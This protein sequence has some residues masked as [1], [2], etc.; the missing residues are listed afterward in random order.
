[1]VRPVDIREVQEHYAR[2]ELEKSE[3]ADLRPAEGVAKL[4]Q[5]DLEVLVTTL[6]ARRQNSMHNMLVEARLDWE[7]ASLPIGDLCVLGVN[8]EVDPVIRQAGGRISEVARIWQEGA[9]PHDV[10]LK[11]EFRRFSGPPESAKLIAIRLAGG[12]VVVIDGIHRGVGLA[13]DG[14]PE[15]VCYITSRPIQIRL[16]ESVH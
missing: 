9:S 11:R 7:E 12:P 6:A 1:M 15:A 16:T 4:S 8:P 2:W 10:D 13:I 5:S 14:R 3:H